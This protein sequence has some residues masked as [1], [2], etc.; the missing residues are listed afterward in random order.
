MICPPLNRML[1]SAGLGI[2][3]VLLCGPVHGDQAQDHL[4]AARAKRAEVL[5]RLAQAR[6]GVKEVGKD[7]GEK[8][9]TRSGCSALRKALK[10]PLRELNAGRDELAAAQGSLGKARDAKAAAEAAKAVQD[11]LEE[12]GRDL[13]AA[14]EAFNELQNQLDRGVATLDAQDEQKSQKL[15]LAGDAELRKSQNGKALLRF[16]EA[17]VIAPRASPLRT[18]AWN[19][20]AE[21][22]KRHSNRP[23]SPNPTEAV[24][25]AREHLQNAEEALREGLEESARR[26]YLKAFIAA[27]NYRVGKSAPEQATAWK[28]VTTVQAMVASRAYIQVGDAALEKGQTDAAIQAFEAAVKLAPM[29]SAAY[30]AAMQGLGRAKLAQ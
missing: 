2:A 27:P 15:I 24:A 28:G 10:K 3:F 22:G 26:E 8:V 18:T 16:H 12:T 6:E 30:E 17:L 23:P 7:A 13:T 29:N 9:K 4:N 21:A 14:Q 20:L 19:R 11:E 1:R 25:E 5:K